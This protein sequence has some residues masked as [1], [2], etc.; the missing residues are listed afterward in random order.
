VYEKAIETVY[1]RIRSD[2]GTLQDIKR[3]SDRKS[4]GDEEEDSDTLAHWMT[5][6]VSLTERVITTKKKLSL[7]LQDI[8]S[9]I[10]MESLLHKIRILCSFLGSSY[11]VQALSIA[12]VNRVSRT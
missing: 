12:M 6:S 3:Q 7:Y 4:N 5:S 1:E 9:A 10:P 2:V 11:I 8:E